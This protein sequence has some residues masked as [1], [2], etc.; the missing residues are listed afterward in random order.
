MQHSNKALEYPNQKGDTMTTKP[1]FVYDESGNRVEV[2][3]AMQDYQAMLEMVEDAEEEKL[4]DQA[5]QEDDGKYL[6]LEEMKMRLG[7]V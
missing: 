1:K 7:L 2:I 5:K 6:T 3:L 4:Y